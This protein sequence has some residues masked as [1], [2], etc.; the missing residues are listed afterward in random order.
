MK[1]CLCL[2]LCSEMYSMM[3]E[4]RCKCYT[5]RAGRSGDWGEDVVRTDVRHSTFIVQCML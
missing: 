5:D 3:F 4:R 1:R 2:R